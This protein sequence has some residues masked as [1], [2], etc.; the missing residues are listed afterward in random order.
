LPAN[1]SNI[2]PGKTFIGI[3]FG[4]STTVVSIATFDGSRKNK[5]HSTV[6]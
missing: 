1:F 5:N 3:D 6:S 2:A 4:T